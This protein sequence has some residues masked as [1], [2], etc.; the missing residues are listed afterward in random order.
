MA[1]S[2]ALLAGRYFRERLDLDPDWISG[3]RT[4]TA[5]EATLIFLE[6]AHPKAP[7]LL[8][9]RKDHRTGLHGIVSYHEIRAQPDRQLVSYFCGNGLTNLAEVKE[10]KGRL[11]SRSC[12]SYSTEELPHPGPVRSRIGL[13]VHDCLTE[14]LDHRHNLNRHNLPNGTSLSFDFGL[15][16]F[17]RYYPPFYTHE[18][19]LSDR[20]IMERRHFMLDVLSRYSLLRLQP[21]SQQVEGIKKEYPVTHRESLIRYYLRNFKTY[22]PR[23][24]RYGGFFRKLKGAPFEPALVKRSAEAAGVVLKGTQSWEELQSAIPAS[25]LS[26]LDLRGLDLSRADLRRACL[27]GADL[28][29]ADLTGCRLSEA[30][31]RGS[32]LRGACLIGTDFTGAKLD[33][34]RWPSGVSMS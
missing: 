21:E 27:V 10:V 1:D 32:D 26:A 14:D 20:E 2:P 6:V 11:Y 3:I 8:I 18:L 4:E 23:R 9:I 13:W 15:A 34:A 19:G 31:L 30:D 17:C 7:S 5:G 24:L 22:F 12:A 29:E 25:G 16:F 28:R 33:K